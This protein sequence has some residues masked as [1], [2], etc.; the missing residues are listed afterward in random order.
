MKTLLSAV[1]AGKISLDH[2]I[3]MAPATRMR[4]APGGVPGELM[5]EYY[6]Q[7]ASKGGLLIA[8][9]TAISPFANAYEDAPGIFTDA[10]QAGWQRLTS[11]VHANGSQIVL[12]L[13]HPGRQSLPELSHGHQPVAP[14][15]LPARETYGVAK[16]AQGAY[17]G[18]LFPVPR[19][20]ETDEI[21]QL[22]EELREAALRAKAAGFD[23]VELHAANGYLPE[24]FLSEGSNQRTDNYGGSLENRA[25]FL[26]E[27]VAVLNDVW[28]AGRVA[29]RISPSGTYGDMHES[30]PQ[31]TF[32]YLVS[33]L[34]PFQLAYLHIIEPRIVGPE[35][36]Q[37]DHYA[38][39]VAS[40]ELRACYPG[41][42]IAAG[43]FTPEAAENM[44]KSGDADLIAFGRMFTSNPDLP[45]RIRQGYPLAA[46]QRETFFGGDGRGYTDFPAYDRPAMAETP[47]GQ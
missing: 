14:S 28:G 35:D 43:G 44:L 36:R 10:Q 39:P 22:M 46:Y 17:E 15:A 42:I 32:R 13:W 9:A 23:G 3:V 5:I 8:E 37:T 20:L 1:S 19:A 27:S 26:L 45:E 33:Q 47:V 38:E 31:Q 21:L 24:Q 7:R 25:R 30:D 29:V 40:R 6:R 16:N 18:R 11:A 4:T 12:Q 34:I 2:R 41:T